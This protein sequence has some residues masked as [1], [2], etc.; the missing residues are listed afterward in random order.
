MT[1]KRPTCETFV[2]YNRCIKCRRITT[3]KDF[4]EHGNIC[5]VC[6]KASGDNK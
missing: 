1:E 2:I 6:R 5:C 4:Y 3:K